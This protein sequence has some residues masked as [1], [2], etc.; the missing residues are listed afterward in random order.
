MLRIIIVIFFAAL[1]C[2]Q[3]LAQFEPDTTKTDENQDPD[4]M[5]ENDTIHTI[6]SALILRQQFIRDS[7][8]AREKFVKDSLIRRKVILDSVTFLQHELPKLVKAALKSVNE[9]IIISTDKVDIIGDSALSDFTYRVLSQKIEKPYAPWRTTINFSDESFNFKIDTINNKI[10]SVRFPEINYSL[11]YDRGKRI[12]RMDGRSTILRK[13]IGNFYK[14]PIDSVFFNRDGKVKKIKK[15]IH[16]YKATADYKKGASLAVDIVQIKEFEYFPDGVLSKYHI[17]SYCDRFGGKKENQECQN[18]T[19]SISREGRK[20][21]VLRKNKPEN[22]YTDGTFTFEFDEN[23]DMKYMEFI[24]RDKTLNRKCFV[25]LNEDGYVKRYLYK[26]NGIIYR[27]LLINY[28]HEPNAD[29]KVETITCHFEDDGISY[30]QKN[31]R[32]GKKRSRDRLTM[33]WSPWK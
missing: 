15:Y 10:T 21:K 1:S 20:F 9:E 5:I 30:F 31:N 22:V 13:R 8:I 12:V 32:T 29:Y 23:F 2:S 24:G 16:Y 7:L 3:V 19:Y 14:Y 18:V 33:K 17:I 27:T 4:L 6:D 26:K 25:E 28:N 11:K